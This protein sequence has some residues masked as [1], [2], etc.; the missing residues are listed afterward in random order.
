MKAKIKILVTIQTRNPTVGYLIGPE[1]PEMLGLPLS[2]L[3]L[4]FM[5][6]KRFMDITGKSY[7]SSQIARIS[8]FVST[9]SNRTSI[10]SLSNAAN[11][12]I[13]FYWKQRDLHTHSYF[14]RIYLV[15]LRIN[16]TFILKMG[17][18]P[19]SS[20]STN[21]SSLIPTNLI[22]PDAS[23]LS[24]SVLVLTPSPLLLPE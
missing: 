15:I 3:D 10:F 5:F 24:C 21:L 19:L 17:I 9:P 23:G 2:E 8:R 4:Y 7:I 12:N 14:G 13:I 20:Y 16:Q 22:F 6:R 11:T 1:T 18:T